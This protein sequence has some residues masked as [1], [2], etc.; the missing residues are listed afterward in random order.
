[1]L[2]CGRPTDLYSPPSP[3]WAVE[4]HPATAPGEGEARTD[5]AGYF[6]RRSVA[7][8]R[9]THANYRPLPRP[10]RRRF[11]VS[12]FAI[13]IFLLIFFF[14]YN[15]FISLPPRPN[16]PPEVRRNETPRFLRTSKVSD[17]GRTWVVPLPDD[18]F[19]FYRRGILGVHAHRQ[20]P[21][22]DSPFRSGITRVSH[23]YGDKTL[24]DSFFKIFFRFFCTRPPLLRALSGNR[25]SESSANH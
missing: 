16:A 10:R 15:S 17:A 8:T 9:Q 5:F 21:P 24:Y 11:G 18:D 22:S 25:V 2:E 13:I 7:E 1:M 4:I 12:F 6:R 20:R 23:T 19:F 3:H 14:I